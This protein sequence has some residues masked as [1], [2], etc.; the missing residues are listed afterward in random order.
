ML[1]A[2]SSIEEHLFP[3]YNT[4]IEKQMLVATSS[5]E[6]HLF[7][8]ILHLFAGFQQTLIYEYRQGIA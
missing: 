3:F 4:T 5:I 8:F 7:S 2:T 1:V 6:E